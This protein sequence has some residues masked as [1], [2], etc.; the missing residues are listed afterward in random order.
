MAN[1]SIK[2]AFR[3]MW[4]HTVSLVDKKIEEAVGSGGGSG[5]SGSF[6]WVSR[7]DNKHYSLM[8]REEDE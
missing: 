5:T 6:K 3:R 7:D 4:E 8:L 2:D 1:Q